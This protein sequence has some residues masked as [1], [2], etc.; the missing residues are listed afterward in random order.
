MRRFASDRVESIM[1]RFKI[2]EDVPIEAK[3]VNNAIE[4]AQRQVESQNFEI[5][6]NVLKY[7]EVMNRQ[8][9]VI[10]EWRSKILKGQETEE[11]GPGM[12]RRGGRRPGRDEHLG[13]VGT[14]GLELGRTDRSA[15]AS[16]TRRRVKKSD[17]I[18]DRADGDGRRR[19]I[20]RGG[21][22]RLHPAG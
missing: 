7:D 19:C 11:S 22:G 5:R 4:R 18:D 6:K 2:P 8:R 12:D 16:C 1:K 21:P 14:R 13:R 9:E 10:Y 20:H 17:L 3:M 15:S